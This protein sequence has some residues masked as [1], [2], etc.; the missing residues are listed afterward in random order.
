MIKGMHGMFY[1]SKAQEL[2]SFLKDKLELPA[3]D[4]GGGWLMFD[5][6]AADLGVHPVEGEEAKLSGTH[7]ISFFTDDVKGTVKELERKGVK[8]DDEIEDHGYGLVT[9][10]TMPGGVKVQL[11]E[12]KY[13]KSAL[14]PQ[15]AKSQRTEER[16]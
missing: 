16:R 13:Q 12:P 10:F 15:S 14:A 2:R 8:F 7:D 4:I 6:A 3:S 1:S 11:Y 9:H 5:F